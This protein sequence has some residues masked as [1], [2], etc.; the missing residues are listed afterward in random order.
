MADVQLRT[1][2]MSDFADGGRVEKWT[3]PTKPTICPPSESSITP[4]YPE[5]FTCVHDVQGFSKHNY[6]NYIFYKVYK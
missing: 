3:R 4:V 1:I 2:P 6:N 5:F